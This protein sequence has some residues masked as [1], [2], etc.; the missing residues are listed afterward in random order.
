MQCAK[1]RSHGGHASQR[2]HTFG[3]FGPLVRLLGLLAYTPRRAL[4]PP[5][6]EPLQPGSRAARVEHI[7]LVVLFGSERN[8][9]PDKRLHVRP[10]L[11]T[12][13]SAN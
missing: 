11:R 3:T 13:G 6:A 9:F 7:N 1:R 4:W 2:K 12:G 5:R 10:F 8:A